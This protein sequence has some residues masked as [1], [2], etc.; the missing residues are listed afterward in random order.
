[1]DIK[2][3]CRLCGIYDANKLSLKLKYSELS[4]KLKNG[5]EET[6]VGIIKIE[7]II[8]EYEVENNEIESKIKEGAT[9]SF[10]WV[11]QNMGKV[12]FVGMHNKP[13]MKPLDSKTMTGKVIDTISKNIDCDC[14]KT[15]LCNIDFFPK[16]IPLI[17][18]C[19]IEWHKLNEPSQYDLIVL[20][21][22]WVQKHFWYD[23]LR[24]I[25]IKHPAGVFGPKKKAE[26][27]QK[28]ILEISENCL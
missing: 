12:I 10:N 3:L 21:G 11:Q 16:D 18:K 25:K 6:S 14:I 26:Y 24:V 7:L 5:W 22:G 9:V 2:E 27:I 17:N 4:D 13:G 8:K 23:N 1:M 28:V 15:N 19:A 20:L